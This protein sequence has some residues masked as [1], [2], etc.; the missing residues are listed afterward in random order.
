MKIYREYI[1]NFVVGLIALNFFIG[2]WLPTSLELRWTIIGVML[3]I[4][5]Y[6]PNKPTQKSGKTNGK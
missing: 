5:L 1:M 6:H 4:G 3:I 2:S